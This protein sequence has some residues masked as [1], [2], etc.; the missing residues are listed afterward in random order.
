MWKVNYFN[1]FTIFI[2]TQTVTAKLSNNVC[3]TYTGYVFLPIDN[4][5]C[6]HDP[7]V[8]KNTV[9]TNILLLYILST[10][11]GKYAYNYAYT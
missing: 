3:K 8:W 4:K 9:C 5:D 11:I 2:L 10:N 7:D 1:F 6:Y